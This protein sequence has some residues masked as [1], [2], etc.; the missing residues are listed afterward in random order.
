MDDNN[1]LQEHLDRRFDAIDNRLERVE[2]KLDD[3]LSRLS[4]AEA[5]VEWLRG[6]VKLILTI[7]IA[8]AGTIATMWMGSLG[9]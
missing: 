8:C 2:D 4:H 5:S 6:N 3:N 9:K 1:Y 7:V